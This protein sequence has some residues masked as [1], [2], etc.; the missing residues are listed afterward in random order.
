MYNTRGK[1]ALA[2]LFLNPQLFQR[3]IGKDQKEPLSFDVSGFADWMGLDL[4]L[5]AR[6]VML[7]GFISGTKTQ[8]WGFTLLG[9]KSDKTEWGKILPSNAASVSV[10]NISDYN[11][12]LAA[13]HSFQPKFIDWQLSVITS[14][15]IHYT[16]LY[17]VASGLK[18]GK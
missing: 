4:Y 7:S 1:N 18:V 2:N 15:S 5:D 6:R 14:Y 3:M 9:Q 10:L 11:T 8:N 17:D 13:I 12:Y 16:K